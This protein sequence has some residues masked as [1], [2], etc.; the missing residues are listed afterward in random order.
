MSTAKTQTMAGT[1]TLFHAPA[2]D[3]PKWIDDLF[4]A[5]GTFFPDM[6]ESSL[7]RRTVSSGPFIRVRSIDVEI[8]A[9]DRVTCA[10]CL[11]PRRRFRRYSQSSSDSARRFRMPSLGSWHV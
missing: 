10:R 2:R 9:P 3:F 1:L 11:A 6:A 5:G 4:A 7:S 8:D